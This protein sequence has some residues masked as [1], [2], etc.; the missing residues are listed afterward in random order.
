MTTYYAYRDT[1]QDS[2]GRPIPGATITVS[3]YPSGTATIYSDAAGETSVSGVVTDANGYFEFYAVAG[4]YTVLVTATGVGTLT[5]S[6]IDIGIPVGSQDI[7]TIPVGDMANLANS[8]VLK[9]AIPYAF[10][11]DSVL[12]RVG[13]KA[14]STASKLATASLQISGVAATGGVIA[15]TSANCAT[16]GGSVA[17]SAVTAGNTGAAGGTVEFAMSAVTAFAEGSGWFEITLSRLG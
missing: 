3:A 10:R 9:L 7:K 8:Q 17:G 2:E 1:I 15:L 12:Y 14:V 13:D 11:V 4:R 16:S 5:Y 6:P